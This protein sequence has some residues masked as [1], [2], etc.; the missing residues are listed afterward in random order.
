MEHHAIRAPPVTIVFFHCRRTLIVY[1]HNDTH[2]DELAD[3]LLLPEQLID[4]LIHIKNILKSRSI[5]WGYKLVNKMLPPDFDMGLVTVGAKKAKR[6][7]EEAVLSP[8]IGWLGPGE[9]EAME[10]CF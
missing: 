4:M 7:S 3:S 8:V 1:P 5:V 6:L 2:G 9:N 10:G